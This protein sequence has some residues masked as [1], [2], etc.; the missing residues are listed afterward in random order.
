MVILNYTTSIDPE[1]TAMEI[2][3]KLADAKAQAILTEY[4]DNGLLNAMSFRIMTTYGII[5]F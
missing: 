3:R 5:F 1:K 4:N 2:Q